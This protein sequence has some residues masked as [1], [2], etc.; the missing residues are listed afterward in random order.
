[1][2]SQ[3]CPPSQMPGHSGPGKGNPDSRSD[4]LILIKLPTFRYQEQEDGRYLFS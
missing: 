4:I 3:D 1:M 2:R